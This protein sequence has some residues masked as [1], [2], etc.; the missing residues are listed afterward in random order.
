M[1]AEHINNVLNPLLALR[2]VIGCALVTRDGIVRHYSFNREEERYKPSIPVLSRMCTSF[3]EFGK[4]FEGGNPKY[5]LLS[6]ETAMVLAVRL[7]SELFI[8]LFLDKDADINRPYRWV[9]S[10]RQEILSAVGG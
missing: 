5:I 7:S 10:N 4:A 8:M 3:E 2:S 6:T 1:E 9:I